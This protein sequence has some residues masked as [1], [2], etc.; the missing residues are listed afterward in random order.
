MATVMNATVLANALHSL[1]Y[2]AVPM[3]P[4]GM[5]HHEVTTQYNTE[6]GQELLSV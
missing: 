5:H 2:D 4:Q 6:L 3:V 1:G